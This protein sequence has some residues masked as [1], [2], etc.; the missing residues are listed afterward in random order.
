LE[1]ESIKIIREAKDRYKNVAV[2]DSGDKESR[3]CLYFCQ[4][5]FF[6][7]SPFQII[8]SDNIEGLIKERNLDALISAKE[9]GSSGCAVIYPLSGWQETDVSLYIKENNISTGLEVEKAIVKSK[10]NAENGAEEEKEEI[11]KRL[12]DLGYL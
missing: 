3:V 6:G 2:F 11:M 9:L 5:T 4:R 10:E 1:K 8:E 12:R 7:K